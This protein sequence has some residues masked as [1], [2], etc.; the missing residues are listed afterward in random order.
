MVLTMKSASLALLSS[1][2]VAASA[3]PSVTIDAG[4]LQGGQCANAK[5]AV[6]YKAIPFAEPPIG[7]LRFEPPK[8]YNNKY[9]KGTRNAKNPPA[10]CLQFGTEFRAT[11]ELSE[12]W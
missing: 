6:Y 3:S 1:L 12:D 4:T 9:P 10:S 7:E 2:A 11:G 8:A 5:E